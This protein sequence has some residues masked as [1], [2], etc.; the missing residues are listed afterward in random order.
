MIDRRDRRGARLWAGDIAG[1]GYGSHSEADAALCTVLAFW[2][3]G[4]PAAIDRLFRASGLCRAKW[5]NRPDY[6]ERTISAALG[7]CG[8]TF[9]EWRQQRKKEEVKALE[10]AFLAD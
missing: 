6:R 8:E 5:L 7:A 1:A 2:T 9:S 3:D 10:T 4:D